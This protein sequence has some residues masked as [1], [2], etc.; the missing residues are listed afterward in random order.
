MIF[1]HSE[2]FGERKVYFTGGK[3]FE[4]NSFSKFPQLTGLIPL[5]D[6]ETCGQDDR[7]P[8]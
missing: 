3:F 6:G 2:I 4:Q 7:E 1:Y 8:G 5:W